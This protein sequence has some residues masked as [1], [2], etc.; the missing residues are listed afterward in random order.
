[1]L[2]LLQNTGAEDIMDNGEKTQRN[3]AS[4]ERKIMSQQGIPAS[5]GLLREHDSI[6]YLKCMRFGNI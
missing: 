4:R 1:M 3:N 6:T 5:C 2:S